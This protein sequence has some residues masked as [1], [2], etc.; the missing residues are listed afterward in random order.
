MPFASRPAATMPQASAPGLCEAGGSTPMTMRASAG[1]YVT[2]ARSMSARFHSASVRSSTISP[3]ISCRPVRVPGI[4][5]DDG[6]EKSGR[7]EGRVGMRRCARH[8]GGRVV[9]QAL[10]QRN[11]PR[12]GGDELARAAARATAASR[13]SNRRSAIWRARRTRPPRT[14]AR[15]IAPGPPPRRHSRPRRFAIQAGGATAPTAGLPRAGGCW[16]ASSA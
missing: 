3:S 6:V 5:A 12:R 8:R 13:M 2:R 11:R 9:H 14:A 7:E 4:A 16:H 10:D 1:A 15:A